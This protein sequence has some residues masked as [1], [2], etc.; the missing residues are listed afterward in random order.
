VVCSEQT[1]GNRFDESKIKE[2]TGGDVLSGRYMRQDFFDFWPSHL[3]LVLSNFLPEVRE[4]GPAF[5]RRVRLIPF[6]H[7][8]PDNQQIKDLHELLLAAEGPAILGWAVQGAVGVLATGLRDPEAVLA[9]TDNYR[10]N[11]DTVA[12]RVAAMLC[13]GCP[14]FDPCGAAAA[15]RGE[16]FG[17]WAGVDRTR[18]PYGTE[19]RPAVIALIH[20]VLNSIRL[21][22]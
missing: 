1:S 15:A 11:E 10:T 5:W 21:S 19:G 14:V 4:G 16:P 17:V 7:L 12:R 2:L 13:A 20:H 8:V 18:K 22:A 3:L 6:P 9:A